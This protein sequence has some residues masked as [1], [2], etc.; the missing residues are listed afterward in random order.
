MSIAVAMMSAWLYARQT[1][2]TARF[3][4]YTGRVVAFSLKANPGCLR[5][6]R[7]LVPW[8]IHA[9]Q[10]ARAEIAE[11]HKIYLRNE[12]REHYRLQNAGTIGSVAC[13]KGTRAILAQF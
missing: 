13:T 2:E 11:E 8:L 9:I 5:A 1:T 6:G 7:D 3:L 4:T 10:R 12:M